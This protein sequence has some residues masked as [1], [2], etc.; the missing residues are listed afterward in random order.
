MINCATCR[1]PMW[2]SNAARKALDGVNPVG[3]CTYLGKN[4]TPTQGDICPSWKLP[5]GV[6][7]YAIK[8]GHIYGTRDEVRFSLK[9]SADR[10]TV[11][12]VVV[13]EGVGE[14]VLDGYKATVRTPH[15]SIAAFIALDKARKISAGENK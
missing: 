15:M 5:R 11:K 8:D 10:A 3:T 2:R 12:M 7:L 13:G 4:V 1:Y 9:H 6:T 14:Q